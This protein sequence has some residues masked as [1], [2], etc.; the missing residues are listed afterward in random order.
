MSRKC[1]YLDNNANSL[2]KQETLDTLVKWSLKGNPSGIYPAAEDAR[3]LMSLFS[4]EIARQ[5]G[6]SPE[7]FVVLFTS[8]ASEANTSILSMATRAYAKKKNV[9]P[10]VIVSAVEHD[11]IMEWEKAMQEERIGTTVLEVGVSS[12][13]FSRVDPLSLKSALRGNTCIVSIMGSNNET[14]AINDLKALA[15]IAHERRVP[16]HSDVVQL[17]PREEFNVNYLGLDAFSFSFHKIGGPVGCGILAIRKTF[18]E[19]YDLKAHICGTQQG[20]LRGGTIP[21]ANIAASRTAFQL[22]FSDRIVKNSFIRGLRLRFL[23]ELAGKFPVIFLSEYR[24]NIPRVPTVVLL[25]SDSEPTMINTLFFAVSKKGICNVKLRKKLA[26]RCIIVSI[27]S[28]CKTGSKI[29]SHVLSALRVP[30][31]LYPG[32]LRVSLG[33]SNTTEEAAVFA[34]ELHS[35]VHS[36]LCNREEEK[37]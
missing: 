21:I 15:A 27:G 33:D 1:I 25:S 12:Y 7:E 13:C 14:G 35:L 24:R 11:S 16:F 28:A 6:F 5:F 20:K 30:R 8:G 37:P 34:A 17:I 4:E 19:G 18:V 22:H 2:P 23:E 9:Q 26:E 36:D 31:E 29:A 3:T 32:V 10:H